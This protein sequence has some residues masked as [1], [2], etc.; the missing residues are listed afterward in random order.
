MFFYHD[1]GVRT[2]A[3]G[4]MLICDADQP[5]I[6][7]F[8]HGVAELVLKIPRTVFTEATGITRVDRPTVVNFSAGAN[9]FAHTLARQPGAAARA[10]NPSATEERTLLGLVS[11]LAGRGR[12]ASL[13][14]A[15]RACRAHVHRA[16]PR[17]LLTVGDKDC[18]G[19][20]HQSAAP[21][22]RVRRSRHQRAQF[23]L[24]RRLVAARRLL[25]R[26]A[27]PI[28]DVAHRLVADRWT[29]RT[30]EYHRAQVRD[31]FG[32]REFTRADED[33]LADWLARYARSSCVTS[34]FVRHCWCVA[35]RNESNRRVVSTGSSGRLVPGSSS[36]SANASSY[37]SGNGLRGTGTRTVLRA[38]Y[39][40][41]YR[42]MLPPLL[43]ALQFRS[44]NTAYRP[45]ID[46]LDLLGR[47]ADVDGKVRFYRDTDRVPL[48]GMVPTAGG[49]RRR[50]ERY[51]VRAAHPDRYGM[52]CD[53]GKSMWTAAP[54]GATPRTICRGDFDT[55]RE[56]H[57]AALRQPLDPTEFGDVR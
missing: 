37:G 30:I 50:I 26:Q 3:P 2:V 6:R 51:P 15:H 7:G 27:V 11:A 14:E 24:E 57:S 8:S 1:D 5:F 25:E 53:A 54:G 41:Y 9:P 35:E 31:A 45:V 23:V 20:R 32:F 28:G 46:A 10:E 39:S 49:N 56:V 38:R 47:Y 33:T 18:R 22:P 43:A 17:R 4:Q 21:A 55:A 52:R 44:N 19:R 40:T 29:G 12:D 13:G 34:T 48:D 16:T 42:R 36:G